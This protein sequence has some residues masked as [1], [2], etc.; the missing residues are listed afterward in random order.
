MAAI[1][2]VTTRP[3]R[4]RALRTTGCAAICDIAIPFAELFATTTKRARRKLQV[5]CD[6]ARRVAERALSA[7]NRPPIFRAQCTLGEDLGR[8][9]RGGGGAGCAVNLRKRDL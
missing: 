4:H 2:I 3:A 6:G 1:A 8:Q 5:V 9:D 7:R